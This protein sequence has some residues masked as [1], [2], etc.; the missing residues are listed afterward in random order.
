M[1]Q[2]EN[3]IL[4]HALQCNV[5][6]NARKASLQPR[7]PRFGRL[8]I[9]ASVLQSA[10]ESRLDTQILLRAVALSGDI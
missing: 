5:I 7:Q 3:M 6:V 9:T 8:R 1:V 2:R 4:F 10:Q